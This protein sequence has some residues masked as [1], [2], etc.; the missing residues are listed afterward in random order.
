MPEVR[1]RVRW[2]DGGTQQYYSPSTVVEQFLTVGEAYPVGEFVERSRRALAIA[3][4]R[5]REK[6]GFGCANAAV[7]LAEI[8]RAAADFGDVPD[9]RV[10]VEGFAGG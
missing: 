10:T 4:E 8:E 3:D 2:P 9:G 6:Y 1:F 5:V 7:A